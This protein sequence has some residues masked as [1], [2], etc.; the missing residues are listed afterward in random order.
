MPASPCNAGNSSSHGETEIMPAYEVGGG[1]SSPPGS[2]QARLAQ[3]QSTA[4]TPRR[5]GFDSLAEY[6][7]RFRSGRGARSWSWCER[8]RVPP[9]TPRAGCSWVRQAVCKA[10]A[11]AVGVRISPRPPCFHGPA[12]RTPVSETGSRR[13]ESSWKR[14]ARDSLVREA[15]RKTAAGRFD[16]GPCLFGAHAVDGRGRLA[17]GRV[18]ARRLSPTFNGVVRVRVPPA[19]LSGGSSIGRA[20]DDPVCAPTFARLPVVPGRRHRAC[21]AGTGRRPPVT[22]LKTRN[23]RQSVPHPCCPVS[24]KSALSHLNRPVR[25]RVSVK[26]DRCCGLVAFGEVIRIRTAFYAS[27]V[28]ASRATYREDDRGVPFR[29]PATS[30]C[31]RQR[32]ADPAG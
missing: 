30:P 14:M 23:L 13:F 3:W 18:E 9:V 32:I 21:G 16:S 7:G 20:L 29:A 2:A 6:C 27:L 25:A 22:C 4:S 11:S 15:V 19:G 24:A 28:I 10:A 12:D 5:K 8:V 26:S 1:G 31:L 17:P